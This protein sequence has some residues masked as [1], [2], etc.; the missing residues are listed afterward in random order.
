MRTPDCGLPIKLV[1]ARQ[2]RSDGGMRKRLMVKHSSNP[3]RKLFAVAG[4][5]CSS[6]AGSRIRWR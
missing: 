1:V 4:H 5:S 2:L 6:L 3:S